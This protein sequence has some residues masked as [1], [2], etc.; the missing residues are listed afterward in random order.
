MVSKHH[1]YLGALGDFGPLQDQRPKLKSP[2][3]DFIAGDGP[4]GEEPAHYLSVPEQKAL[5]RELRAP[6][7]SLHWL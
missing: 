7:L 1:S 2:W 3:Q 6:S 5:W 4:A